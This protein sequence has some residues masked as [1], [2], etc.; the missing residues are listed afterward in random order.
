MCESVK[1]H[2]PGTCPKCGM[3]LIPHTLPDP[4]YPIKAPSNS[5][6]N[7]SKSHASEKESFFDME[8][9]AQ[10]MIVIPSK[11]HP[12][13]SIMPGIND[14]VFYSGILILLLLSFILFEFLGRR[15]KKAQTPTSFKFDLLRIPGIKWLIKRRWFQFSLQIPFV[16]LFGVVIF[17]GFY[18]SPF[19]DKNITPVLTW[20][21]WWTWLIFWILIVGKAWCTVCPWMAISD[22]ITN[23]SFYHRVKS[24]FSFDLKWPHF[25]SNIWLAT[26][27]FLA[28]TWLELGYNVTSSPFLTA[29]MGIGMFLLALSCTLIFQRKSF[30]RYGCLVGRVSGLY[31]LMAITEIRAKN[32]N[33]CLKCKT[34]DC[35]KG[36]EDGYG[37]PTFQYLGKMNHNTYCI[38]CT[39]C[40]K[41]CPEDNVG[42]NLRPMGSD[43]ILLSKVRTDEA[44][45]SII[46]LSMSAFHGFSMIPMWDTLLSWISSSLSVSH[47]SSFSLGMVGMLLI[48]MIFYYFL[49]F[50]MRVFAGDKQ[51]STHDIFINFSYSLLPVALFYH[52]AHN[53][54]HIFY[55]GMKFIRILSDPFGW[56]WDLIGTAYMPIDNLLPISVGWW[57]QVFLIVVGHIYGILVAHK[58]AFRYYSNPRQATLS[59]IPMLIIMGLFSLQSLWLLSRPMVMRTIM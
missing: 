1:E 24:N 44:Y 51:S 7:P 3:D 29:T 49:C 33:I 39:E 14:W 22:W 8:G 30:C 26:I 41:T 12:P 35:L 34:K 55:E 20:T 32:T 6:H 45:L 37:C 15:Q 50:V 21:I 56:G 59:Q 57:I 47:L 48:P 46:M 31:S 16:F 13:K 25:L 43:L 42:W 10:E 5:L 28:L 27:L 58:L 53:L 18:G 40:F 9:L 23:L 17:G 4:T 2:Q 54:Q 38:Y 11:A 36:N 19:P 52:L